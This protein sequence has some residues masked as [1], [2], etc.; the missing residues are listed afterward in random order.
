MDRHQ[1]RAHAHAARVARLGT[2]SRSGRVDLVPVTFAIVDDILYTAV[3]HK[4]KTTTEL[5]RLENVRANPE[6]S[7]LIDEYDD[8]DWSTLWWVRL[9]GLAQ[10]IEGNN[11]LHDAAVDALVDKYAQYRN[12][13]PRG[14]VIAVELIRWQWWSAF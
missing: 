10:V 3:D 9:R 11:A 8:A 13:R 2:L 14:S 5:K 6:V 12:V 4:P 7:V 1:A